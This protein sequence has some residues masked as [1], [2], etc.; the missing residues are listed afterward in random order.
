M[1]AACAIT[2]ADPRAEDESC[3]LVMGTVLVKLND[4]IELSSGSSASTPTWRAS[5]RCFTSKPTEGS[6]TW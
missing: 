1:K 6:L 4:A 3:A 2:D 5:C